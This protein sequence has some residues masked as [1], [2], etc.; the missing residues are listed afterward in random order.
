M[1]SQTTA[2][3]P[4]Q[5]SLGEVRPCDHLLQ[6]YR[7]DERLLQILEWFVGRGLQGDGAVIVIATPRHLHDLELRLRADWIAIDQLR[8]Q[9]RYV[10]LVAGEVLEKILV[11]GWPDE[12]RFNDVM[13]KYV[14]RAREGWRPVRVFGELVALLMDRGQKAATV[15]LEQLWSAYCNREGVPLLCAY[16]EPLFADDD[17]DS[18]TLIAAQHTR[19]LVGPN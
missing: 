15:R 6:I 13:D 4:S 14:A 8:W 5:S 17:A 1:N 9:G 19:E 18:K 12:R 16:H 2:R 10:P 11:N 7:D 3:R